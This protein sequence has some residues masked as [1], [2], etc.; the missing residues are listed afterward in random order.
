VRL[1]APFLPLDRHDNDLLSLCTAKEQRR[2]AKK[3]LLADSREI[4]IAACV[5]ARNGNERSGGGFQNVTRIFD[6]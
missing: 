5:V 2:E 4:S 1:G 3:I 6:S